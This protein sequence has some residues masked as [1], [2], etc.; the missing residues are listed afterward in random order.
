MDKRVWPLEADGALDE[1][2]EEPARWAGQF[3]TN[4]PSFLGQTQMLLV[5]L[6]REPSG[7]GPITLIAKLPA[8]PIVGAPSVCGPPGP[9]SPQPSSSDHLP[10]EGERAGGEGPGL[11]GAGDCL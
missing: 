5:N 7:S 8:G 2:Q 11:Q 9:A 3:P 4:E 1:S 6:L 10:G